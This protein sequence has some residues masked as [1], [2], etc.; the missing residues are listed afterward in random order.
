MSSFEQKQQVL[1]TDHAA[2]YDY[3]VLATGTSSSDFGHDAWQRWAPGLKSFQDAL[4]VRYAILGAFEAAA[5]EPDPEKRLALF[6][7]VLVGGPTGVELAGRLPN[8]P[9][10]RW[11]TISGG[12]T[13]PRRVS[14]WSRG[15]S[16]SFPRSRPP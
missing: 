5:N 2:P 12:S 13:L 11:S 6:T 15:N 16:G 3:L 4:T 1:T 8:W 9:T 7:S 14:S 10:G